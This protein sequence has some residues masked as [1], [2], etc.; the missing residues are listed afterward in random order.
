MSTQTRQRILGAAI[1]LFAAQPRNKVAMVDVAQ[2]VGISGPALYRYFRN[3]EE[4]F[5]AAVEEDLNRLMFGILREFV[6]EP[7]PIMGGKVWDTYAVRYVNHPLAGAAVNSRD[8]KVLD[9]VRDCDSTQL[10]LRAFAEEHTAAYAAGIFRQ[11]ISD[12]ALCRQ[13]SYMVYTASIPLILAGK[14]YTEE[15]FS[16]QG[17]VIAAAFYPVP[18]WFDEVEVA[19]F[20]ARVNSLGP[21]HALQ[22]YFAQAD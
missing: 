8:P 17:V 18:N 5:Y 7:K 1:E 11:D 15:W 22:E 12:E 19:A 10:L 16:V 20:V 14:H 6:D 3:R 9:L 4:L 2:E 13:A 21:D